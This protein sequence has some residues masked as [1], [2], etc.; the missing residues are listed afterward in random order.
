MSFWN[1]AQWVAAQPAATPRARVAHRLLGAIAEAGLI[2]A[3]VFGLVAG[4]AFAAKGGG[5]TR[6][7]GG[8]A[9]LAFE[10]S[11]GA[12]TAGSQYTVVATGFAANTWV[13][14]GAHYDTTY[15]GSAVTD[16]S[17]TARI[18]F[19]ALSAGQIYHEAYQQGNNGRM[20]FMTSATLTVS[21]SP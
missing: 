6:V 19:T 17:G 10:S 20:R 2:T 3:L 8:G 13:S 4:S 18:A 21:T 7:G 15:W 11:S 12:F 1:G 16:A 14:V 5:H 9:S